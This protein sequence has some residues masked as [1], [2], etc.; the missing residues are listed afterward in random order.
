VAI[1][2]TVDAIPPHQADRARQV[3]RLASIELTGTL[4]GP[5]A[6]LRPTPAGPDRCPDGC[7]WCR[8]GGAA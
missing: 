5:A 7:H 4:H 3:R 1:T 2:H 6:V 8:I